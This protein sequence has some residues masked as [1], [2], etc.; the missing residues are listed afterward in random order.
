MRLRKRECAE[1]A[2]FDEVFGK[3]QELFLALNNN[4]CPYLIPLNFV[5]L[6][7]RIYLHSALEGTKLD[8]IRKDG[9]AAFS[10]VADVRIEREKSTT[11]YKSVCGTGHA[12]VVEDAEEKRLALD[13][14]AERYAARCPRPAPDANIR[15]VAIIRIDIASLTGKRCL[16]E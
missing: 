10:L 16:P 14:L 1:Q 12:S 5:R 11:Y 4:G 9:R 7:E 2:F 13:S 8:L 6:G 15:R 3:A